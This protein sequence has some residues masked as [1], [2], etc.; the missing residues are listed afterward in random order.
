MLD[1]STRFQDNFLRAGRSTSA[2]QQRS[3]RQS[4]NSTM[5][6]YEKCFSIFKFKPSWLLESSDG[7][8]DQYLLDSQIW[9]SWVAFRTCLRRS[10][11]TPP[12]TL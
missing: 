12:A 7:L 5:D 9:K 1:T 8:Y 4:S 3:N 2:S 6:H 10:Q 11:L